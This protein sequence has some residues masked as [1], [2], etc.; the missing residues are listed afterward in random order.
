MGLFDYEFQLE[1]IKEHQ[2]PLQKLNAIIDWEMFREVI[3]EALN[4]KNP[5]SNAGAKPYDGI[6]G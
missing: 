1:K 6:D 5:K 4:K 2:P 3:E